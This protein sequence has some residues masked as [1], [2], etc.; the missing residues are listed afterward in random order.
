MTRREPSLAPR[1][2]ATT[3]LAL[4][5]TAPS[6]ARTHAPA[7]PKIVEGDAATTLK[8]FADWAKLNVV[9]DS[10]AA[11]A[12]THALDRSLS[13]RAALKH[14]LAGT[15][16]TYRFTDDHTVFVYP[17]RSPRKITVH[18]G[19]QQ[20]DIVGK[21][22][23]DDPALRNYSIDM[24]AAAIAQTGYSTLQS[25]LR[26]LTQ[27][28]GDLCEDGI[29]DSSPES[30]TNSAR[31]CGA[32]LR[33]LG[34]SATKVVLDGNP[35][36]PGGTRGAFVDIAQ[37]P[38]VAI[39]DIEVLPDGSSPIY[40][41]DAIAG[42]VN[43]LPRK[44]FAGSETLIRFAPSIGSAIGEKLISEI[45]GWGG[46][47]AGGVVAL[48]HYSRANLP[49]AKRRQATNDLTSL[50]GSNF[51]SFFSSPP[52]IFLNGS[53][54]GLQVSPVDGHVYIDPTAAPNEYDTLLGTDILPAQERD[55]AYAHGHRR[56]GSRCKITGTGLLT[57]RRVTTSSGAVGEP[58]TVS[59]VNP[60]YPAGSNGPLQIEYGFQRD[61]GP[62][63]L[64]AHVWDANLA[65]SLSCDL[66]E[67]WRLE[68][69]AGY[70]FEQQHEGVG[71]LV[72]S[73]GLAGALIDPS[74]ATAFDPFGDPPMNRATIDAIRGTS[75]F[76]GDSRVRFGRLVIHG[77]AASGWG[78][79][80]GFTFGSD[81]RSESLSTYEHQDGVTP[82]TSLDAARTVTAV[83]GEACVPLNTGSPHQCTDEGNGDAP[84]LHLRIS[85]RYEHYSDFGAG[86]VPALNLFWMPYSSFSWRATWSRSFRVPTLA[87]LSETSNVSTLLFLPNPTTS[88][89]TPTL[90][91]S[92]NNADLRRESARTSSLTAQIRPQ[93]DPQ[94]SIE[95]HY[96]ATIFANRIDALQFVEDALTD[97]T[98][99]NWITL[100]P[101]AAQQQVVCSR[102]RFIG[103]STSCVNQPIGAIADF[104]LQN[105]SRLDTRGVDVDLSHDFHTGQALWKA[106][107]GGTY[108][109][110]YV[111][112]DPSGTFDLVNTLGN[113]LRVRLS[114][115]VSWSR[116]DWDANATVLYSGAYRDL[117]STP[118]RDVRSW[119]TV[120]TQ[121]GWRLPFVERAAGTRLTLDVQNLFGVQPP[122]A[123]DPAGVGW[124][125]DNA[126]VLGRV[127]KL[128][129]RIRL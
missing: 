61:L 124:D 127:V 118:Y 43:F 13:P 58:L 56:L 84:Q 4:L 113:P 120:N 15:G 16:L 96:W 77:T 41:A 82:D 19:S 119:T 90:V 25:A 105:I 89:L 23:D 21:R 73:T 129:L 44:T 10:S 63:I 49:A 109:F 22:H 80:L 98:T 76:L 115:T 79:D 18:D 37:I 59:P 64:R 88:N 91:W 72:N 78:P 121:I 42:I 106:T 114:S 9:F 8:E 85:G 93:F 74:P 46:E 87:D 69:T 14:L 55:S 24:S 123:N 70:T 32:N 3:V 60:F 30:K 104:R 53:L 100:N 39:E 62:T 101:S 97:P 92:G 81:F 20:I 75:T 6:F 102:S 99:R 117:T 67:S 108:I 11:G 111:L 94:I 5:G 7:D 122:F 126:N 31:G 112:A 57:W 26:D 2:I 17:K 34:A 71:N 66:A 110:R 29:G 125:P 45:W 38:V 86:S 51:D 28:N 48:E 83:F 36:A 52:N 116:R 128:T 12:R 68:T 103:G 27:S 54:H 47:D 107:L 65:S 50:G 33:G 1:V 40:G 35:M 95:A